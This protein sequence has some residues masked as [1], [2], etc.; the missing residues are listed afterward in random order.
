MINVRNF[1]CIV[2]LHIQHV[3]LSEQSQLH[4]S[5]KSRRGHVPSHL[6]IQNR[7]HRRPDVLHDEEGVVDEAMDLNICSHHR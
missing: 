2:E 5:F 7:H 3:L 6:S 1:M 4:R